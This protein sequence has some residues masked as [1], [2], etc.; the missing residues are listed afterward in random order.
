MNPTE[1]T[2]WTLMSAGLL[3]LVLLTGVDAWVTG[4]RASLR[5]FVLITAAS[6]TF[7]VLS[8]L[9]E[10]LGPQAPERL[11]LALKG[12]LGLLGA[13]L[14]LRLLAVWSGAHRDDRF[15]YLLTVGGGSAALAAPGLSG[16][17][18]RVR[19][20]VSARAAEAG[21]AV[22]VLGNSG[23]GGPALCT[24]GHDAHFGAQPDQP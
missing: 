17:V 5:S 23:C 22:L 20:F 6:V 14:G 16:V 24:G 13:G 15:I 7:V 2:V 1:L 9:P 18:A 10:V 8:G 3:S 19:G 12:S 11:W 4:S 21:L